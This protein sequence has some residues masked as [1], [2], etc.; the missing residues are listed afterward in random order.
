MRTGKF[1]FHESVVR[2][3]HSPDELVNRYEEGILRRV[4][5]DGAGGLLLLE[6]EP[7]DGREGAVAE[8][9]MRLR[10]PGRLPRGAA[11]AGERALRHLLALDMDLEPFYKMARRDPVLAPLVRRFR[12][13]RPVRYLDMFEALVTAITTQQV[14]LTFGGR[15]RARMVKRWGDRLLLGGET[16]YAFP[17]PERLARVRVRT[18]RSLQFSERKAEYVTGLAR[19]AAAGGL[20]AEA[21]RA[22]PIEE[23]VGLLTRIRGIGRWTAEQ[24]L[25]RALGRVEAVPAGDLGL[26]KVV[27]RYCFG[28]KRVEEK[29]VR[30]RARRWEPWGALAGAYLF[31]AWRAD[32]PAAAG[33]LEGGKARPGRAE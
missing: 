33:P 24:A 25:F 31:A 7:A 12:G 18:L 10:A 5:G 13:L 32:L 14:N 11:E 17:R 26:Q 27:A 28:E 3:R 20:D 30:E 2:Y 16:H 1:L 15:T 22:L 4:V 29:R 19:E 23:A 21:L 6:A 9:E 8:I